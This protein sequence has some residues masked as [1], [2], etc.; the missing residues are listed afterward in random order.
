MTIPVSTNITEPGDVDKLTM[1]TQSGVWIYLAVCPDDKSNVSFVS[2]AKQ[3]IINKKES[4][5]LIEGLKDC[6][7]GLEE[8]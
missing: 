1:L 7:K 4:E 6:I 8:G 3:L 2:H 5:L